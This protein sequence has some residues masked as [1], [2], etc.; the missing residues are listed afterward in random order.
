MAVGILQ[1]LSILLF[2]WL[3]RRS[4]LNW[5]LVV[6][7]CFIMADVI[8]LSRKPEQTLETSDKSATDT[9]DETALGLSTTSLCGLSAVI[10][11]TNLI[12]LTPAQADTCD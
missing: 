11:K 9:V 5:A 8:L 1:P 4:T 3:L 10:L 12:H 2:E 7:G 6:A